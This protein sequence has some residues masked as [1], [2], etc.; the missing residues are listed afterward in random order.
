MKQR[1]HSLSVLLLLLVLGF[2][3][4]ALNA[5]LFVDATVGSDAF[6]GTSP[7]V[8][9]GGVGPKLTIN[10]AL[11]VAAPG[12]QIILA[13]G[14][15]AGFT[16]NLVGIRLAGP[17]AAISPND[18]G[19]ITTLNPARVAEAVING[20]IV[21]NAT[22]VSISGITLTGAANI[23][24]TATAN[25][26]DG[27]TLTKNIFTGITTGSLLTTTTAQANFAITDNRA[28]AGAATDVAF[29]FNS[30][31]GVSQFSQNYL[32]GWLGG[33]SLTAS[34]G[35]RVDENYFDALAQYGVTLS[36]ACGNLDVHH[37]TF[38]G[39]N[40]S[41]LGTAG[42]LVMPTP[43]TFAALVDIHNNMFNANFNGIAS[44]SAYA[45]ALTVLG[46]R[47]NAFEATVGGSRAIHSPSTAAGNPLPAS[48]NWFG[49]VDSSAIN[50][51]LIQNA[52]VDITPYLGS[53]T[54]N[55]VGLGFDPTFDEVYV[56]RFS[57]QR[58]ADGTRLS[59]GLAMVNT[60][61]TVYVTGGVYSQAIDNF[62][63]VVN[64]RVRI[65]GI[66]D[67][68]NNPRAVIQPQTT[69]AGISI[70]ATGIDAAN[71]VQ[72]VNLY[73]RNCTD[74][75][76]M[77]NDLDFALFQNLRVDIGGTNG[78]V[79]TAGNDYTNLDFINC[80]VNNVT[81]AGIVFPAGVGSAVA[82]RISGGSYTN[83]DTYGVHFS[84]DAAGVSGN[85]TNITVQN[86][87][88]T[89]NGNNA[90]D[91][92]GDLIFNL[93]NGNA[94]LS[95][96]AFTSGVG[97]YGILFR[98]WDD[99]GGATPNAASFA[100]SGTVSLTDITVTGKYVNA[101]GDDAG[102]LAITNYL[103]NLGGISF[104]NVSLNS[105]LTAL[106]G[107]FQAGL[108]LRR[109]PAET[110][111]LGNTFFRVFD[112]TPST[113]SNPVN[114]PNHFIINQCPRTMV[115]ATGCDFQL[116]ATTLLQDAVAEPTPDVPNTFLVCDF[117]LDGI[118][119]NALFGDD[120]VAASEG[121]E[122][123]GIV[124]LRANRHFVTRNSFIAEAF[125]NAPSQEADINRAIFV[126]S[127]NDVITI[128]GAGALYIGGT[129]NTYTKA[130]TVAQAQT[131]DSETGVTIPLD[132]LTMN[133]P[134]SVLTLN[135]TTSIATLLFLVD[136]VIATTGAVE[137]DVLSSSAFSV[138][139][140]NSWVNGNL[141][142]ALDGNA[143]T[144]YGFPVGTSTFSQM[145]NIEFVDAYGA[146]SMLASFDAASPAFP[147]D[148]SYAE[149]GA[150][151]YSAWAGNGIWTLTPALAIAGEYNLSV[152]PNDITFGGGGDYT[153]ETGNA[154]AS[155]AKNSTGTWT[156]DGECVP[157]IASTNL[158]IADGPR[159]VTRNGL[160]GFSQFGIAATSGVP[161]PV[162]MLSF[163]ASLVNQHDAQLDWQT[164]SEQNNR[165]FQVQRSTDNVN[166]QNIGWVNGGGT[167]QTVRGYRFTDPNLTPGV[168]Y[169]RLNQ[170]DVNG[171]ETALNAVELRVG[172]ADAQV[173]TRLY[174]NPANATATVS[175]FNAQSGTVNVTVSNTAGQVVYTTGNQQME[176]GNQTLALPTHQFANGLYNVVLDQNGQRQTFRLQVTR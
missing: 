56:A 126:A 36:G 35:V 31:G 66:V 145:A 125:V 87:T 97:Q 138:L 146:T 94:T 141:R 115:D 122:F 65:E 55:A 90:I 118:D 156:L 1:L 13:A 152:F 95:N 69:K 48:G 51:V 85:I 52:R 86:A 109:L 107:N 88:F 20:A 116:N 81:G 30:L 123:G 11:A 41:N 113:I 132:A 67:G 76:Q 103:S 176:S 153:P 96:L 47:E 167:T 136:G 10:G 175:F 161:Y 75:V 17:N 93:F 5:Q 154:A 58:N 84:G 29:L 27:L 144:T 135:N 71:Q 159:V 142:R 19:D 139:V 23:T 68:S 89:G 61:G 72:V 124:S 62:T 77:P 120:V 121:E 42:A 171:T 91:Q 15:Y 22:T 134:A 39:C 151:A 165:G 164:A 174:P 14:T 101:T 83:N 12:N 143:A 155:I 37:N 9:G 137:V 160:T 168:Y 70:T 33:L 6:D 59:E 117:I 148:I 111:N 102:C 140:V 45:Q 170:V 166:F 162:E 63:F 104:S 157:G 114:T 78:F 147:V 60:G 49:A 129:Y 50:N 38:N 7:T 3:P 34:T 40:T 24:V 64:K 149:C 119:L 43:N 73:F 53:G 92:S 26:A 130:V 80:S 54:N 16:V 169:Y 112:S 128:E 44:L 4:A 8:D 163:Q 21:V 100:A 74:A 82:I 172:D 79:A 18:P 173:A 106:A 110:V 133:A 32:S 25:G 46:I 98:G 150:S 131:F 127:A 158:N 2:A 108:L 57:P 99:N 28:D 105:D